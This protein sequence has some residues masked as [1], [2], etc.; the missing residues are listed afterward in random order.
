MARTY[1]LRGLLLILVLVLSQS[2]L[3]A[4]A[5]VHAVPDFANCPLCLG[6]PPD[7]AAVLPAA[8]PAAAAVAPAAAPAAPILPAP[9]TQPRFGFRQRAP[10][11]A[12]GSF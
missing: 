12:H 5:S 10:P 6:H 4:H 9:A 11:A 7:G 1:P 2:G 3:A 8:P